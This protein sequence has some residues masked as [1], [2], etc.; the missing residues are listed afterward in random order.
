[1]DNIKLCLSVRFYKDACHTQKGQTA[2]IPIIATAIPPTRQR[3]VNKHT[4]P[5][6]NEV[7]QI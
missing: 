3:K 1:M 6:E 5:E 2:I 4:I 7:Q